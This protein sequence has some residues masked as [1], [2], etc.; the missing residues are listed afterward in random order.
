MESKRHLK[1][2]RRRIIWRVRDIFDDEIRMRMRRQI[3]LLRD[4]F[5]DEIERRWITPRARDI[6]DDKNERRM[7]RWITSKSRDI[8]DDR[9]VRRW[10]LRSNRDTVIWQQT[11]IVRIW[12]YSVHQIIREI[13][14]PIVLDRPRYPPALPKLRMQISDLKYLWPRT[15]HISGKSCYKC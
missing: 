11:E 7:R 14:K 12:F 10:N 3:L 8:L 4:I 15:T 5:E 9:I 2:L 1:R 13:V 6:F